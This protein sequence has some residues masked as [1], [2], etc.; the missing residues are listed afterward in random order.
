MKLFCFDTCSQRI[1]ISPKV[2]NINRILRHYSRAGSCAPTS[3]FQS[4]L[5]QFPPVH[6][7][8]QTKTHQRARGT[9]CPKAAVV[10]LS[11]ENWYVNFIHF[12]KPTNLIRGPQPNPIPIRRNPMQKAAN[13]LL[14][15]ICDTWYATQNS[16]A[17]EKTE[18]FFSERRWIMEEEAG[19]PDQYS[20]VRFQPFLY[21]FH[22]RNLV[23]KPCLYALWGL[24]LNYRSV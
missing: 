13:V 5:S 2:Y 16:E 11:S 4:T 7:S 22:M 12:T 6:Q 15:S 8:E 9:K 3:Y 1:W 23:M 21:L 17:E 24:K 20:V 19:D 14:R 18:F 10:S